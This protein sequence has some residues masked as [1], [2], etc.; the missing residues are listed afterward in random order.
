MCLDLSCPVL[1]Y[2]P[3]G[4]RIWWL[5]EMGFALLCFL[6][7]FRFAQHV[8]QD[9]RASSCSCVVT[10]TLLKSFQYS[11]WLLSCLFLCV[12]GH[13]NATARILRPR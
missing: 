13:L 4:V 8:F 7:Q 3:D 2:S 11:A 10:G 9:K 6:S 5:G 12:C 1:F